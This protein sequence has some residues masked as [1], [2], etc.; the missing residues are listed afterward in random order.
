VTTA[1]SV[2][3]AGRSVFGRIVKEDRAELATEFTY[4]WTTVLMRL[5]KQKVI[6]WFQVT[7]EFG[8]IEDYRAK[9]WDPHMRKFRT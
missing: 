7:K 5:V 2:E 1:G 6:S 3:A 9:H 4:G 8:I